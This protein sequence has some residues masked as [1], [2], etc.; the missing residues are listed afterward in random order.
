MVIYGTDPTNLNKNATGSAQVG[1]FP[2]PP[3]TQETL[4]NSVP[5]YMQASP[6]LTPST[7][8][9]GVQPDLQFQL[10]I[11]GRQHNS[12]LHLSSE[13]PVSNDKRRILKA[14]ACRFAKQHDSA[15]TCMALDLIT[16]ACSGA[17]HSHPLK[18]A[19]RHK[20]M[21]QVPSS[22]IPFLTGLSWYPG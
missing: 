8:F 11:L 12:Q 13:S 6:S 10:C 3:Q 15:V 2:L 9:A 21:H 20:V 4:S 18:F 14:L 16:A 22:D 19:A 5:I 17:A 7:P 1:L